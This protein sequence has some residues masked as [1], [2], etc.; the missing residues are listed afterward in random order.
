MLSSQVTPGHSSKSTI[1]GATVGGF[2]GLVLV[3]AALLLLCRRKAAR[4]SDAGAGLLPFPFAFRARRSPVDTPSDKSA[5]SIEGGKADTSGV[6][7]ADGRDGAEG[8]AKQNV[9]RIQTSDPRARS[10]IGTHAT[11]HDEEPGW[12]WDRD[13]G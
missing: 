9:D 8:A 6:P 10:S 11:R 5:A 7:T 2:L 4:G 3:V 12:A 13:E 1:I